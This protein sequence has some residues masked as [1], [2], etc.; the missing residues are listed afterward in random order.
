MQIEQRGFLQLL[1]LV[2][3]CLLP[4]L[5]RNHMRMQVRGNSPHW[6]QMSQS[7]LRVPGVSDGERTGLTGL[8]LS[9]PTL[10]PSPSLKPAWP[11]L[12]HFCAQVLG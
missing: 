3:K 4:F 7:L 6:T 11:L 5:L 12:P 2:L 9:Q 8:G 10:S 1:A